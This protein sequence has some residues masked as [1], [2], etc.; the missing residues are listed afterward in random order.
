MA[1]QSHFN[2]I[3]RDSIRLSKKHFPIWSTPH[4]LVDGLVFFIHFG[5]HLCLLAFAWLHILIFYLH[6]I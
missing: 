3:Q 1:L 5:D 2:I 6:G 4:V